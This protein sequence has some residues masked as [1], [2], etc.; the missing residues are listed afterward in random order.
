MSLAGLAGLALLSS[1]RCGATDTAV[2][3][4]EPSGGIVRGPSLAE[5]AP[6]DTRLFVRARIRPETAGALVA[7]PVLGPRLAACSVDSHEAVTR[8]ELAVAESGLVAE[9]EGSLTVAQAACLLGV[10]PPPDGPLVVGSVRVSARPGGMRVIA[11]PARRTTGAGTTPGAPRAGARPDETDG[12]IEGPGAPPE[13]V[14]ALATAPDGAE[15]VAVGELGTPGQPL[16][17]NAVVDEGHLALRLELGPERNELAA[18]RMQKVLDQA[19]DPALAAV[20]VRAE[21]R[22]VLIDAPAGVEVAQAI[23]SHVVE[24]FT[25]PSVSML[26]TLLPGDVF[27][28]VKGGEPSVGDVVAFVPP[29]RPEL[30][31]S[32][33]VVA[34]GGQRVEWKDDALLVD[35]IDTSE[36]LPDH[37][38]PSAAEGGAERS[39]VAA[40]TR[41][42]RRFLTLRAKAPYPFAAAPLSI[43]DG[44]VYLVGDNRDNSLDSRHFGPVPKS[45]VLGEAVRIMW[46]FG[47]DGLRGDRLG[48][49]LE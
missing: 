34:V 10:A 26:P 13:L 39:T 18:D 20:R 5:R 28:V 32:K 49:P 22:D 46:S 4:P 11:W 38:V 9:T 25:T 6:A 33:R 7:S 1:C 31:M 40:E 17:L 21:G 23:R 27:L 12:R 36:P 14:R 37:P 19:D 29:D 3:A 42:G 47:P 45:A 15:L 8:V 48:V 24:T 16:G 2:R 41:G 44:E 35:G 43:P 30:R